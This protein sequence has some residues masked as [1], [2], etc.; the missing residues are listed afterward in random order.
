MYLLL[1][2]NF[3]L[4]FFKTET[5]YPLITPVT[6]LYNNTKKRKILLPLYITFVSRAADMI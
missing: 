5:V 3:F 4:F 6:G 1:A 2:Y